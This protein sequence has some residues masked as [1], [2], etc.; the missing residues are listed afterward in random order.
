MQRGGNNIGGRC[1][2]TNDKGRQGAAEDEETGHMVTGDSVKTVQSA[3][4][5][6]EHQVM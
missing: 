6:S 3:P 5:W 2:E 4:D 1:G